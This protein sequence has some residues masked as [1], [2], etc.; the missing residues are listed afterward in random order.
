[1]ACISKRRGKYVL[2][3][4]DATGRRHAPTFKTKAEA[5][6]EMA[7]V[8]P[9]S[10]RGGRVLGNPDITV[11]QYSVTWFDQITA[12]VKPRTLRGYQ[13]DYQR[14]ISPALGLLRLG[15]LHKTHIV[16]FLT[17]KLKAGY[18]R[19]YVRNLLAAIRVMLNAAVDDG[20]SLANPA[21]RLGKK[22]RLVKPHQTRQE[23]IK[24]FTRE[25]LA[26]FLAAAARVAPHFAV[27][28][29]FLARAGLR[30][31]EAMVLKWEDLDFAKREIRVERAI[32]DDVI[33][34]PKSGHGRTVDMSMQLAAALQALLTARKAE[35]LR[36]GWKDVPAW[37]FCSTRGTIL[38]YANVRRAMI[39]VL[40]Q[41]KLPPHFTPHCMRHTF[42]SLL[43][44]AGE[45]VVYVQRQLGHASIQLTVDTYGKWLP[46]GNKSAVDR[47]DDPA[48]R[49]DLLQSGSKVVA[50][51]G[52][53]GRA[54]KV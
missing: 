9:L 48:T 3:Y 40:K 41:A 23:E 28:F 5:E 1:M 29:L 19:N 11:D 26:T 39:S 50:K 16:R 21:D 17:E 53:G 49:V 44:S 18:A 22:L 32:S 31:G 47:L 15:R 2:D 43:L 4:R 51:R 7:R 20:V 34:T 36:K 30:I 24:A 27:L 10:R 33:D 25:H 8:L 35:T 37:V 14:H 45:S 52:N 54:K 42:A 12:T 6:D 46:I 13:E 38:T